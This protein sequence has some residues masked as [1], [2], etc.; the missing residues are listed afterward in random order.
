MIARMPGEV[1][2]SE[3]ELDA[4]MARFAQRDMPN[5]EF[6]HRYHLTMAACSVLAGRSLDDIR[7]TILEVN[8]KN[9]VVQTT[10]G[11]YHETITVAWFLL[12]R[13]HLHSLPAETPRLLAVNSVLHAFVD[14]NVLLNYYSKERLM[15]WEA[16]KAFVEP[17]IAALPEG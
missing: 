15:S 4:L 9:K 16:R 11:G 5:A 6:S 3:E 8:A 10:T 2:A 7:D 13:S 17:D 1:F 12:I 14:K